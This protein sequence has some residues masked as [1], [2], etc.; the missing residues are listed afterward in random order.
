MYAGPRDIHTVLPL[1]NSP[2]EASMEYT[3]TITYDLGPVIAS[4]VKRKLAGS[5]GTRPLIW[6][7][8]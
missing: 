6:R 2:P 4:S 5:L 3:F 8:H 1:P 7:V